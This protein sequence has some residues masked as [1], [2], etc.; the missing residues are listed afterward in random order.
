MHTKELKVKLVAK[1]HASPELIKEAILDMGFNEED[2]YLPEIGKDGCTPGNLLIWY[3]AKRCYM[4]FGDKV[5][6]NI[7]QVRNDMQ[8]IFGDFDFDSFGWR[9]K[10]HKV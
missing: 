10:F 7:T 6:K 5:N 3:A 1:T 8:V 9:P 2:I 4:A